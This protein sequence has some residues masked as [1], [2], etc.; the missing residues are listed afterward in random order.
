MSL[1]IT[2]NIMKYTFYLEL[3]AMSLFFSVVILWLYFM[4]DPE[5]SVQ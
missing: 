3:F 4:K 5:N 1:L 2:K